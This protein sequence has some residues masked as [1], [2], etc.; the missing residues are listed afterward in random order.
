MSI[1]CK[2]QLTPVI[3]LYDRDRALNRMQGSLF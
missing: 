1:Y 2:C 3:M